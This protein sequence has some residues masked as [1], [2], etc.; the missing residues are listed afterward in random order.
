MNTII[1]CPYCRKA[2]PIARKVAY[3]HE[4]LNDVY[5]PHCKRSMD[6]EFDD[7]SNLPYLLAYFGKPEMPSP[8]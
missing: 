2:I 6:I 3:G 1:E 8:S 7:I 5:C 4:V